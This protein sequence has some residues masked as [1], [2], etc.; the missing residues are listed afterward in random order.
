M[1]RPSVQTARVRDATLRAELEATVASLTG[2]LKTLRQ[3][4]AHRVGT[5]VTVGQSTQLAV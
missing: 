4:L 5:S 3:E 1:V 2:E